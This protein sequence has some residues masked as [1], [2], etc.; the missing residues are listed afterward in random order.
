MNSAERSGR[1]GKLGDGER[2]REREREGG[3]EGSDAALA[4]EQ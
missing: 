1:S 2:E 3:K 4:Q